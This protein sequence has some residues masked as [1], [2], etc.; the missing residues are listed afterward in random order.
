ML[1]QFSQFSATTARVA[2]FNADMKGSTSHLYM[3]VKVDFF[4][5]HSLDPTDLGRNR[6]QIRHR[7]CPRSGRS[8]DHLRGS[9]Q[10]WKRREDF[11]TFYRRSAGLILPM[12]CALLKS[13][14]FCFPD[15]PNAP[16]GVRLSDIKS[17]SLEV[18]WIGQHDGN[19]MVLN[20]IVEY[21]N[22]PGIVNY[23]EV[24][25]F[26]S[27]LIYD[28]LRRSQSKQGREKK[29]VYSPSL[30]TISIPHTQHRE[31][32]RKLWGTISQSGFHFMPLC[33]TWTS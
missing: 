5:V 32:T 31:K 23:V 25:P 3:P 7:P 4:Q 9:Q 12:L 26:F 10:I 18:S 21:S 28:G 8:T 11:Y 29:S 13:C 22:L 14:K 17:R 30:E 2:Q 20:Y 1:F 6:F 33:C 16:S 24:V 15:V 19:S 27:I